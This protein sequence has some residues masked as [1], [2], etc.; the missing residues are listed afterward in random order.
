MLQQKSKKILVY[1]FL[2]L[3]IGTLNNKNLNNTNFTNVEKILIQGLDEKNNFQLENDISFLNINNLFF[4]KKKRIEEIIKKN[5]LVENFVVFKKYPSTLDIKIYQ[6]TFLAKLQVDDNNY[7]LGSNGKLIDIVQNDIS[8]PFIYGD[9]EI[10]NFFKLKKALEETN[11]DYQII[12]N[13]FSF[14]SGRWDIET[15]NGLLIKLPQKNVEESLK[16]FSIFL[17]KNNNKKIKKIDLRQH[18]QIITNG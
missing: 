7:V 11:F 6:T 17:K 15:K 12:K 9:F 3:I 5:N 2:L 4:L 13:F 1:F 18:N 8:L 14:K 16:L 10:K